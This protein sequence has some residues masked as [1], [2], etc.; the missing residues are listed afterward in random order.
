MWNLDD[1]AS[2]LKVLHLELPVVFTYADTRPGR[3]DRDKR[4]MIRAAARLRMSN[5][6][7]RA[8]WWGFRIYV[9]KS[10]RGPFDV[11]NVPKLIVDAFSKRQIDRDG[12]EHGALG[13]YLGEV[14]VVGRPQDGLQ[15]VDPVRFDPLEVGG[16][17]AA[18]HGRMRIIAALHAGEAR[19]SARSSSVS[20][21]PPAP[22]RS[23]LSGA[24]FQSRGTSSFAHQS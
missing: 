20:V 5:E 21:C 10:G 17:E 23:P 9:K 11:E 15:V 16:V 19:R 14:L 8:L 24:R 12:S 3:T 22:L 13:V 2:Y 6:I 1:D 7:P 18:C 4:E